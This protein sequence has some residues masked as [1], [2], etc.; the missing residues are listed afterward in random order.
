MKNIAYIGM[1]S[2]L[3]DKINNCRKALKEIESENGIMVLKRSSLYKS[4]PVG[5]KNQDWFINLVIKI[6]TSLIPIDLLKIINNIE[7]K[8]K[9]VRIIRWGPRTIDLDILLYN[10][11]IIELPELRIPHPLL[12]KRRFVLLPFSE[13]DPDIVHPLLNK[14]IS[15]ILK[16]LDDTSSVEVYKELKCV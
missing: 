15:E 4:E 11:D 5:Y 12:H 16:E 8:L 14:K 10:N 13:I 9:R 1:S 7:N 6:K 3:G 2:N